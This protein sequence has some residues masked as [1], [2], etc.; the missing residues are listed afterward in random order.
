MAVWLPGR[1]QSDVASGKPFPGVWWHGID[2]GI[3]LGGSPTRPL[4]VSPRLGLSWDVFGTGKTVVR[5]GWGAYRWNDQYNDYA[6]PLQLSL[7]RETYNL[8]GQTNVPISQVGMLGASTAWTPSSAYTANPGDHETPV[9]YAY[10][11]TISQQVPWNS[12]LEVAYVGNN[13]A[14]LLMGGQNGAATGGEWTNVNRVPLGALFAPDPVTGVMSLNPENVAVNPGGVATGNQLQDYFPYG[15]VYGTQPIYM[16]Q[17]V[18]YSNYNALQTSWLKRAGRLAYN[19][20]YTWSKNLDLNHNI[21]AF[22]V[23]GNY[24]VSGIDR[25][26]VI[27]TSYS[28]SAGDVYHGGMKFLAGAVNGWTISGITTW[29]AGGNLQALYNPNLSLQLN[30]TCP[31]DGA[32]SGAG[33]VANPSFGDPGE[34]RW[35]LPTGVSSG[36]GV[37]TYFGTVASAANQGFMAVMPQTSCNPSSGDQHI[38]PSCFQVQA[39]GVVGPRQYPYLSA[40]AYSNWDLAIFKTFRIGERQSVQFRFSAFNFLNHPLPQ[41]SGSNQLQ[42]KYTKVYQGDGAFDSTPF[43]LATPSSYGLT[44]TKTGRRQIQLGLKYSF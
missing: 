10:S 1:L 6:G 4:F 40:P 19:L 22:S 3:P 7:G 32:S 28:Y 38:N 30:Y 11:F 27:N 43:V 42:L 20:N 17:H 16:T 31:D 24:G 5:G 23:H 26:H 18:G 36:F 35:I 9:T 21:D 39:P 25:P 37:P 14:N 41:F 8:P 44:D 33:C 29:Q 13:S 12:L 15:D 34:A 2:P